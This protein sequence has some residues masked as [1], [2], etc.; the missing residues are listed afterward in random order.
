MSDTETPEQSASTPTPQPTPK[1]KGRGR[2][3]GRKPTAPKKEVTKPAPT[4]GTGRRGR[5]KQFENDEAQAKYERQRELKA[6]YNALSNAM[7]PAL[8]DLATRSVKRLTKD[9]DHYMQ[10]PEFEVVKQELQ[11][12]LEHRIATVERKLA[13]DTKMTMAAYEHQKAAVLEIYQVR[14]NPGIDMSCVFFFSP[15]PPVVR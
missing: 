2:G 3:R 10:V 8:Q 13:H 7:K 9:S 15:S 6:Q 5:F 1:A 12:R 4:I 14:V 11:E